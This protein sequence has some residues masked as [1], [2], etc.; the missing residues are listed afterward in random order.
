M[1][2][3][4]IRRKSD[5]LFSTGGVSPSWSKTGKTWNQ[6]GHLKNHL[7]QF[8]DRYDYDFETKKH[9]RV[10]K[11]PKYYSDCEI[12]VYELTQAIVEEERQDVC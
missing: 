7:N 12:I 10:D 8:K 1:K 4:K 9:I 11:I 2:I 6:I 3:Y 5:G